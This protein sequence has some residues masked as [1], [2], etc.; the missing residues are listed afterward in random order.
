MKD[1]GKTA[2][3][4]IAAPPWLLSA[5]GALLL[6][7]AQPPMAWSLVG[8]IA[9]VP[10]SVLVARPEPL[11]RRGYLGLWVAGSLFWLTT[12]QG[13]RLAHPALYPGWIVLGI[14][15]GAYPPL[16][17]G[18]A[19]VMRHAWRLPLALAVPIAWTGLEL[20][21]SYA[22]T[23]FSIAM[24]GH[25][26]ADVAPMMQIVDTFGTYGVSFV[27]ASVAAALAQLLLAATARAAMP[28]GETLAGETLDR[29]TLA[30]GTLTGGALAGGL[31]AGSLVA[32]TLG[33][34]YWRLAEAD[35]L[36]EQ[37]PLLD[38]LLIQRN[39]PLVYSMD[40]ERE[41]VV[42]NDY[43]SSTLAAMREY[44]AADVVVWPESMFTGGL[45]LRVLGESWSVPEETGMSA[46]EFEDVIERQAAMF[47]SRAADI[48]RMAALAA[49]R[50]A[51]PELLVGSSIHRYGETP[52]A[53]GGAVHITADHEIAAW[54]GKMHLVMFGEY[55]PFG[56]H[57]P[58]LYE[59]GP[60]RQGAT[61]GD[62]P[63]EM[64]IAGTRVAPSVCFETMVEQVTGNSLRQLA[65]RGGDPQLILNITNDAWFHGA[66]ILD[67]HRRC[68]QSI[69]VANR[70][71]LLMAA[72]QGP[73]VW[74]DGSG[75]RIE[76]LPFEV[77]RPLL[78]QPTADGRWSVYRQ[79]GDKLVWPLAI[80]C[81][82]AAASGWRGRKRS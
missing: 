29:E 72:N 19:R 45:P 22:F 70:R 6:W 82:A 53:F 50:N 3:A 5:A 1:R 33:Y 4:A 12:L 67:H 68:S 38:A 16:F 63:V 13:I 14:Y 58:W 40:A 56:T 79:L 25:S 61:P 31:V 74:I 62:G 54:Y 30:G 23:G 60:L 17:V 43:V 73:T 64:T 11:G 21:R 7:L 39:E 55:I 44:P 81:A 20:I 10:W 26:Q 77:D 37:P 49:S 9:L 18:L 51:P 76:S 2:G 48:Q 47:R 57:F 65:R 78:A 80:L 15:M 52:Q 28:A 41:A 75:R 36:A 59:I 35:R 8:W 71:P 27:L 34:G 32:A 24:L 42:F 66:S 69:A 46:S